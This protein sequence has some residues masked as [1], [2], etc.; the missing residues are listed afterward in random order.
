MLVPFP[1]ERYKEWTREMLYYFLF[2]LIKRDFMGRMDCQTVHA[3]GNMTAPSSG[4]NIIHA[5]QGGT[6]TAL[7]IKEA[8]YR[9][10][11]EQG[12]AVL[13]AAQETGEFFG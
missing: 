12:E 10:R 2:P 8:E 9:L 3:P 4:G 7:D 5:I 6:S 11:L 1:L 13:D